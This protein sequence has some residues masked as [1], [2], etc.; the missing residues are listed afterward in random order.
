MFELLIKQL[1]E[2]QGINEA[3]KAQD[4]MAWVRARNN[5]RYAAD[6]IVLI[7]LIYT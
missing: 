1:K 3:L 6:E 5:I 7:E 2:C 4:Q